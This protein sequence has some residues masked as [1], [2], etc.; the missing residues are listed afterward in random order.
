MKK[1]LFLIQFLYLVVALNSVTIHDFI[2]SGNKNFIKQDYYKAVEQYKEALKINPEDIRSN[3]GLSD[4]FFMLGEYDEALLYIDKCISLDRK[5]LELLNNKARILTALEQYPDA[6]EIYQEVIEKEMY[7]VGAQSG[8]AE[9]RLVNGD[10]KGSLFEFEKILKFSPNSRRLLLSLV[11]I[12]DRQ[13][14]FIKADELI[15][16]AIQ[17]YPLDPVVLETSVRHYILK[18]SYNGALLYMDELA[19]SSS[20]PDIMLLH[21][22]LLVY[23]EKLE[24]ALD[25][26]TEYMKIEKD[27]P[28]AYYLGTLIFNRINE[29]DKALSLIK[30]GLDLRPDEEIYRFFGEQI[31]NDYF[32]FKDEKRENYSSW[33]YEQGKLLESQYFYEK[34]KT[35]YSR[36]LDLDPFS[37]KLR[38]AYANILKK[39]GYRERY[40]KE[41]ELVNSQNNQDP[42]VTETLLIEDSIPKAPLYTKWGEEKWNSDNH[43]SV[44]A[45]INVESQEKNLNSSNVILDIA[46][47]FLSS[48]VKFYND[49]IDLFSGNFSD[50]FNDARSID[51]DYFLIINFNE[52]SRTFSLQGTLH[53]TKSG[54]EIKKISYLKT[55]N[56]RIF[57]CFDNLAKD[58]DNF[59]PVVGSV[60]DIKSDEILI[61]IGKMN[62]VETETQFDVIKKGSYN[63]IPDLPYINFDKEKYL[64]RMKVNSVGEAMS[65]GVFTA[66]SSFNL[67]NIGDNVVILNNS[68]DDN[69][70]KYLE[71]HGIID[72]ELISQLLQVN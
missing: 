6:A 46:S 61:N 55:G 40:I 60:I 34:A 69:S 24:E 1:K 63:L 14:N 72:T 28:E 66:N 11:L 45:F 52:G 5:N 48:Q 50:A 54:R 51:S 26:L 21:A 12:N 57:N 32:L 30:R 19:K 4:S 20:N 41:L 8:L 62:G 18:K 27:N 38:L 43:F 10:V 71:T 33:Y 58:L 36:G 37:K 64:G 7:N 15:Q 25:I 29:Q 53:L 59:F 44:S 49:K 23:L 70:S 35:Y 2:E 9:L 13:K 42:E 56:N 47:R 68:E 31:M 3:R 17:L 65:E 67:L 39:L 16:K 22:E